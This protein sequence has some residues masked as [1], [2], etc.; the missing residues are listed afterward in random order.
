MKSWFCIEGSLPPIAF[1]G[2]TN[3]RFPPAL[4]EYVLERF[5]Q[6]GQVVLDPF[7]GLG[8]TLIAAKKMGRV[9]Y[10]FERGQRRYEYVVQQ[11]VDTTKVINDTIFNRHNYQLPAFDLLFTSP[12]YRSFRGIAE[13]GLDCYFADL[14][15]IVKSLTQVVKPDAPIIFEISNI[16]RGN[17]TTPLAWDFARIIA[18][19][20][21][22]EGEIIRCN[23]GEKSAG[24]G[25]NHSYLLVYRNLS[26]K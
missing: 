14:A 9:A 26:V 12:P 7:C 3:I 13:N 18:D 22:F 24:P 11:D 16:R 15:D 2:P 20:I 21:V 5:S 8:T 6:P 10:G 23:T 17:Q 1:K 4:A 25:F 19:I